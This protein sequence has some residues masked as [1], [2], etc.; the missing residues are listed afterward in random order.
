MIKLSN[1]EQFYEQFVYLL[2]FNAKFFPKIE[3]KYTLI[4][5]SI[6][7]LEGKHQLMLLGAFLTNSQII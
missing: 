1:L 5:I 2:F 6:C 4:L 3:S 7:L